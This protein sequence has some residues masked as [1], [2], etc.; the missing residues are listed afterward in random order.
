MCSDPSHQNQARELRPYQFSSS[1]TIFTGRSRRKL[2]RRIETEGSPTDRDG[3]FTGRSRLKQHHRLFLSQ[4]MRRQAVM[5]NISCAVDWRVSTVRIDDIVASFFLF[6]FF[7][8]FRS[9]FSLVWLAL[10][11]VLHRPLLL[12]PIVWSKNG[13][14]I[15]DVCWNQ[16]NKE[17]KDKS[18]D[19]WGLGEINIEIK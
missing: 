7:F 12:A 19:S 11:I 2:H 13:V 6:F 10:K 17:S 4:G 3:S 5:V 16:S 14:Y 18:L 8:F 1:V 15:C 9:W